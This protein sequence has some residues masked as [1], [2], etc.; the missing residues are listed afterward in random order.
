M[1]KSL[2]INAILNTVRMSL[3]VIFPLITFPYIARILGAERLG[4]INY[5]QSIINYMTL[6]ADLGIST[7]GVRECSKIRTDRKNVEIFCNEIFSIN[8]ITTIITYILFYIGIMS[9]YSLHEY[10]KLLLILA[11]S[12]IFNTIGADW[13]NS[14]FEDFFYTTIRSLFIQIFN[15]I[16]LFLFVREQE[17]IYIYAILLSL[18]TILMGIINFVY[19]RKYV[20]LKFIIPTNVWK[21]IKSMLIFFANTIAVTLYCDSDIVMLGAMSN[22]Y[23]VGLYSVAVKIYTVIKNIGA[24]IIVVTIPRLSNYYHD[25]LVKWKK[26]IIQILEIFTLLLPPLV[27]GIFVLAKPIIM[28]LGG[29]EYLQAVSTL[30]ILSISLLVALYSGILT[31]CINITQ[32]R[33]KINLVATICAATLNILL[34]IFMIPM[35][36]QN[37]AAITTLIAEITVVIVCCILNKDIVRIIFSESYILRILVQAIMGCVF[38]V[39]AHKISIILFSNIIVETIITIVS[40]ILIYSLILLLCKNKYVHICSMKNR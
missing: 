19:C 26:L 15:L 13:I 2:K 5:S 38:I 40:S 36:K 28:F 18:N 20:H 22:T 9:S 32:N 35:M 21:H 10:R 39:I 25:D 16:C 33:E 31:N 7:Y 30:R 17:D 6:I 27:T 1:N 11:S 12:V 3:K 23:Y 24:A 8:I 14:V 34:N 4:Q 29:N 37:G